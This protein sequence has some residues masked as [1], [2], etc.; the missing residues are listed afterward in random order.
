MQQPATSNWN[1]SSGINWGI[2]LYLFLSPILAIGGVIVYSIYNGVHWLEPA[3]FTFLYFV[4]GL[5]ITAGFHRCY[6]HKSHE[7]HP[8]VQLFYLIG[9]AVVIQQPVLQWA[10]IHR[11]H[12][13][14]SDTDLDPHNIN[15]GFFYAHMGWIFQRTALVNDYSMVPDLL[16]NRLVMWQKKYYWVLIGVFGVG[17]STLIGAMVGRPLG[18]FLWGFALRMVLQN[19][20]I[21]S[22]NS[23]AHTFGKQTYS[24]KFQARDSFLLALISNGEGYHSFHHRFAMDYRNGWR[25]WH[26]D[27]SKWFIGFMSWFGL[28][29]NLHRTPKEKIVGAKIAQ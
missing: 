19:H 7:A 16:A 15:Q 11:I 21:Y 12:H 4:T 1:S 6:A 22:I 5:G 10:T 9:G 17:L 20:I 26:W 13:R 28:T 23:W 3:Q 2:A 8:I 24:T 18:G 14:Y 25:W 27:P 29:K